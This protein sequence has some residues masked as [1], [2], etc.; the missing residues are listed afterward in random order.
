MWRH[1]ADLF[2][3]ADVAGETFTL[4]RREDLLAVLSRAA[5]DG[6]D[7]AEVVTIDLAEAHR[8]CELGLA[9]YLSTRRPRGQP[10]KNKESEE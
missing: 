5:A 7:M 4:D 6:V 10:R 2:G 9:H 3:G 1:Q 8:K